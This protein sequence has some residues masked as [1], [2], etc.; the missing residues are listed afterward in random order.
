MSPA[1]IYSAVRLNSLR[2]GREEPERGSAEGQSLVSGSKS[3]LN[4]FIR[5][6]R[7]Y[8]WPSLRARKVHV[9]PGL[10]PHITLVGGINIPVETGVVI[11][12]CTCY[13]CSIISLSKL[14]LWSFEK[15]DDHLKEFLCVFGV[16]R[17]WFFKAGNKDGTNKP[18]PSRPC[19]TGASQNRHIVW[20]IVSDRE[21]SRQHRLE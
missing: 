16:T 19:N 18:T 20:E 6:R 1:E 10:V 5:I 3:T 2:S 14:W 4:L 17:L 8:F 13:F 21:M 12:M 15:L 9:K 11:W 7:D